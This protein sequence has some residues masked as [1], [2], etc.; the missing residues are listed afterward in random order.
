MSVQGALRRTVQPETGTEF[1]LRRGADA[2]FSE[3]DL[4]ASR[5]RFDA[6]Y[7]EAERDSSAP[8]M[9]LAALGLGGLWVHEHRTAAAATLVQ[10]RQRHAL[11]HVDP[12][13]PLA[14][15]LRARLA[16]EADYRTGTH[17][18][19]LA[20]LQEARQC[21]DPEAV[22]DALSLAHH[23]LLSPEHG[24]LRR[25]LA[26]EL[27][28]EASRTTRRSDLLMGLLWRTVNLL[29]DGDPHAER[30]LGELRALLAQAEHLAVGFVV[31]AIEVMLH[32]RAGRLEQ[33]EALATACAQRGATAGDADATGW[34]AGQLVTIR[35]FQGRVGELLPM[36]SELVH[37]PT[38]SAIDN[39]LLSGLAVSAATA[40]DHRQAAGALARLCGRDLAD[41]PRSSS[42]LVTLY[43]VVEAAHLLSDADAAA[44]ASA[45]L[46][47]YADLPMM[48][49]LGVSCFGSVHHALGVA[50]MTMGDTERSVEHLQTAVYRNLGLGHWPATALA[51]AR[52]GQALALRA[53]PHDAAT[54]HRQL[55]A[56]AQ[57]AADLGITLPCKATR[58]PSDQVLCRRQG[59]QWYVALGPRTV[60][61]EHS[62]GMLH[63][64]T[65]LAN[66]GQEIPAVDLA[67]GPG[68][69]DRMASDGARTSAQPVLDDVAKREYRQ[70]L[71]RLQAQIGES[72]DQ[73]GPVGHRAERDWL[74]AELAAATGIGGRSRQFAGSE[75]RARVAVG[76]AIRRALHRIAESDAVI[77]EA[78]RSTVRMGLYCVY[79]RSTSSSTQSHT[80]RRSESHDR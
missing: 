32:I 73:L 44:Q 51:R 15:R 4:Q 34:Y 48:A 36:L 33:A 22:T 28:G 3:G 59:R 29:L 11:A 65:L 41:L 69:L 67:A 49:S 70:R 61:V 66:P 47:P 24:R 79:D 18:E 12:S 39:C 75:E 13:S 37:S 31:E 23:C 78:L 9:A 30:S 58:D 10:Q 55:A 46:S 26:L 57:E 76:K 19:I 68:L 63:L 45:L 6:A 77:G 16:G 35:W 71:S 40:G 5:E 7:R 38:L 50:A 43:G 17:A 14:L 27:I 80:M 53:R 2:L 64:A 72:G 60:L 54:A 56:A 25:N 21:G 52:L 1:L 8:A 62:V 74:V 42:W 20:V